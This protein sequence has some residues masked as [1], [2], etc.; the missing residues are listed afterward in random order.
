MATISNFIALVAAK[1]WGLYQLDGNNA[2]LHGDLE[3]E[4]YMTVPQGIPNPSNKVCRLHKS[5]YA[6][7][8][9]SSQWFHKLSTTLLGLGYQHSKNDYSLFLNKSS[10]NITI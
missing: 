9:A 4:V 1:S 8:Q 3:E 10:T 7:Q 2:F 5:F 6:L